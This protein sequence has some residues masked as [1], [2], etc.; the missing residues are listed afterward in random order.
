MSIDRKVFG[1]LPDGRDVHEYTLSVGTGSRASIITFGGILRE[2]WIPDKRGEAAN[3]V[4]GYRS[5]DEY[6]QDELFV[7]ATLG[8][9]SGRITAGRFSIENRD[10]SLD[11][12]NGPNHAHGGSAGFHK[13][14]WRAEPLEEGDNRSA[15][16]LTYYRPDGTG[17]YPGNLAVEVT[18]RLHGDHSLEID[19]QAA[20]DK[21][22]PVSLTNHSYFNLAGEGSN[23]VLNHWL[24]I[25]ADRY[26]PTDDEMT[27]LDRIESVD[28][29]PNDFRESRRLDEA[30]TEIFKHHGDNYLLGDRSSAKPR[31]AAQL[32]DPDSA[33]LMTV[34][35]TEQCVQFYSGVFLGRPFKKHA[36]LCLECQGY[37]NGANAPEIGD[38]LA[39]PNKPYR[40]Q[41]VFRFSTVR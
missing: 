21:A 29:K 41:T 6:V 27:L 5:L 24:Q 15:L 7:G 16:K 12:N 18:Y 8:P 39:T 13:Q 37:P 14:L 3:V 4:L 10:Y 1:T 35:T 22:T 40:Q 34:E 19:Y 2:L 33:R 28:G 31:R 11:I 25:P 23:S 32:L 26:V 20:T 17:G 9:V 38:I 36:A 30:V